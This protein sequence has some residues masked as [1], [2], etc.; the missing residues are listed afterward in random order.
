MSIA[1]KWPASRKQ[2]TKVEDRREVA[3]SEV[4]VG[5][6]AGT[7]RDAHVSSSCPVANSKV[8]GSAESI[9][10]GPANDLLP[11]STFQSRPQGQSNRLYQASA[12]DEEGLSGV[13]LPGTA[14]NERMTEA[15]IGSEA[16]KGTGLHG[17]STTGNN[18][19]QENALSR[20][21]PEGVASGI[22]PVCDIE[23]AGGVRMGESL[24]ETGA[25][26]GPADVRKGCGEATRGPADVSYCCEKATRGPADV[27]NCFEEATR[28]RDRPLAHLDGVDWE[29][30][31]AASVE[32]I[33]DAIKERGMQTRL[34]ER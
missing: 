30:V 28:G 5:P 27:S 4:D 13:Q 22:P 11:M 34:A 24:L 9:T 29:A 1:A 15:E 6:S 25:F 16:E 12:L 23:E 14:T 2:P 32:E 20:S 17:P 26:C 33:A 10:R 21:E 7:S 3:R 18:L 8:D 31:R 19:P